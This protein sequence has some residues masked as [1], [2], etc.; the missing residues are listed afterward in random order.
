MDVV[1]AAGGIGL[2]PLRPLIYHVLNHRDD[3]GRFVLLYGARTPGDI[4]YR[5]ELERWRGRF[6]MDV[7]V[8]VDRATGDWRGNVGVVTELVPRATFDPYHA[9]CFICGPEIMMRYAIEAV[10]KRGVPRERI[11]VSLER[12]MKCAVGFCG[13]CQYGPKFICKDGPV[14]PYDE[15]ATLLPVREL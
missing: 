5:K 2:A 12:N 10:G 4:L 1:V 6:D 9:A 14:F 13:H 8:T 3:Y 15:V 11:Y 7:Q